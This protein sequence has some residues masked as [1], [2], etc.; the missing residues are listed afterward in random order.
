MNPNPHEISAKKRRDAC[1]RPPGEA[2]ERDSIIESQNAIVVLGALFPQYPLAAPGCVHE[3]V[4]EIAEPSS[5]DWRA[6][7][8]S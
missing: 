5:F 3:E 2:A 4:C 8:A 6:R 7:V 1:R